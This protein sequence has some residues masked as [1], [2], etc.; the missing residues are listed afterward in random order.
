[1]FRG[2]TLPI[3]RLPKTAQAASGFALYRGSLSDM[4]LL[5]FVR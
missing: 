2:D 3:I 5:D 4:Q 1:M